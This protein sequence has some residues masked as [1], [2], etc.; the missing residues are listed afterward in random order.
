MFTALTSLFSKNES[1][2]FVKSAQPVLQ[3]A[4]AL[5]PLLKALTREELRARVVAVRERTGGNVVA[6]ADIAE[7]FALAR[8]A[9]SRTL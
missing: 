1:A 2:A 4:A 5:E 9:A 7:V 6:D 3:K 8:A